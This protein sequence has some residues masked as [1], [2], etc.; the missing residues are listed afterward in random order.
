ML[1]DDLA[2]EE[3]PRGYDHP[4]HPVDTELND[5]YA[6]YQESSDSQ[7][8]PSETREEYDSEED[9]PNHNKRGRQIEEVKKM[10]K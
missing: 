1:A 8:D 9:Q 5:T 10:A 2:E 4:M 3:E 7:V 6:K